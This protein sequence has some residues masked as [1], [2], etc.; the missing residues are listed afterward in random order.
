M[1]LRWSQQLAEV[2]AALTT[3]LALCDITKGQGRVEFEQNLW[4]SSSLRALILRLV[5]SSELFA[6][7]GASSG[8]AAQS[9]DQS[10]SQHVQPRPKPQ[11]TNHI[12]GSQLRYEHPTIQKV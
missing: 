8:A 7:P 3:V 6:A 12:A 1:T 4:T 5:R 9:T 10:T 11:T 2:F